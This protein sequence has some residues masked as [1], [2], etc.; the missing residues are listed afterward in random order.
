MTSY[1][2]A[3]NRLDMPQ[4]FMRLPVDER[5]FPVPR[6]VKW[7][8]G[9]PDFRVIDGAWMTVA[10]YQRR[11]WLC[12]DVLGRHMAFVIGPMCAINRVNSEPPSHLECARFAAKA[13]PFL[14]QPNRKRNEHDLPEEGEEPA[15]VHIDRNPGVTLIWVTKDYQ[16]IKTS[17]GVLFRLG[18]PTLLEWYARGRFATREEV[19]SS[20][21]TGLPTLRDMAELEGREAVAALDKQIKV[22]LELVPVGVS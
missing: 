2:P 17:N 13:C 10:V 6:F 18:D 16:L 22:G 8:D 9:K 7:I 15:G 19:M 11:C 12:G 3:I 4:R 21:E 20:I 1:N 14:T 5:G